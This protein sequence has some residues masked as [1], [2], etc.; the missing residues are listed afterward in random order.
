MP[1]QGI[2]SSILGTRAILDSKTKIGQDLRPTDLTVAEVTSGSE[3]LKIFVV[4]KN[5]SRFRGEFQVVSP[6]FKSCNNGKELLVI[7]LVVHFGWEE[8]ARVECNRVKATFIIIL[9]ADSTQCIVRSIRLNDTGLAGVIV[10]ED[11]A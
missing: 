7:D 4:S 1:G 9:A 10:A 11:R 6:V 8:L 5:F 3:V 2:S